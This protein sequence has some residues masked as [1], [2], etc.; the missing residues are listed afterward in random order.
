M[1]VSIRAY[2]SVDLEYPVGIHSLSHVGL[3]YQLEMP[4]S[5]PHY[6]LPSQ[7][8]GLSLRGVC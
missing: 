5:Y 3:R 1:Y 7:A 4:A 2:K 6:L 8:T